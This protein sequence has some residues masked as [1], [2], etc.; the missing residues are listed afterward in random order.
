[1]AGFI[2]EISGKFPKRGDQINFKK[3]TFTIEAL[4]NKRIKQVKTTRNA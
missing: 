2:L 3:Y 4:D 1:L